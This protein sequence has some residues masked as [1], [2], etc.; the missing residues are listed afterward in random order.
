MSTNLSRWTRDDVA[1]MLAADPSERLAFVAS[2][3]S[4]A[5]LAEILAAMANAH[6]G[7]VL[8]GATSSGRFT[9][10]AEGA[11]SR[12]IVQ[13]AGLLSSPPLILPLPQAVEHEGKTLLLIDVP[14]GLP[15]V[16]SVNGRY[17][18]RTGA[19]NRLLSATELSALLLA[20]DEA[21]FESR[22]APGATLDE[23]DAIQVQGYVDALGGG[24]GGSW[25]KAFLARGCLTQAADTESAQSGGPVPT[26][27]GILL[28]G[29]QPQRFLRNAQIALVRYVGPQMGDEFLRHDATGTLPDQIRQAET[30]VTANMRRGM[31]IKGFSREETT[32]YPIPVVR[33]AIVNAVS[34][35]DYAIRGDGIRVL[36]F[37][38]HMEVYSP[39]RLPGHVTLDNLATERFSR[40]EAIVQVLSDLGFVERL[41]YG[42]DRMVAAMAE[43]GLPAPVFEET[44]A[45]FRVTLRGRGDD[46][47][48]AEPDPRWGNRRLNPRQERALA[49]LAAHGAIT[50]REFRELL[51]DLSD[52]TV[53]RELADLVDQGLIVKVGERK[54]TYYILK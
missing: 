31:R 14:P 18:T 24:A 19:Q 1:G 38:D 23:L 35:R 54:A 46:L 37:S 33:E 10:I 8:L 28:F 16:Y 36:M 2:R 40:N 22:P 25:Q 29:R 42:I 44:V 5:R 47:V 27:A 39:G 9:G 4:P 21:G 52:E 32:E 50:N 48:S 12:A 51:P 3:I 49:Y 6:G 17:L 15:H 45:G 11:E 53:R 26:Y 13:A 43:A 34:H 7:V 30:F 20:R 41:G